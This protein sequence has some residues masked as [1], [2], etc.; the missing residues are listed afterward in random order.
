MV[1]RSAT[2]GYID[3]SAGGATENYGGIRPGCWINALPAGGLVLMPDAVDRCRCSYLIKAS[4]AL[5]PQK[6]D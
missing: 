1:F 4:I 6:T 3:L 5:A 2:L